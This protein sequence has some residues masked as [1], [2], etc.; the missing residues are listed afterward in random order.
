MIDRPYLLKYISEGDRVLLYGE[1]ED[2][3][4][5]SYQYLKKQSYFRIIGIVTLDPNLAV[6]PAVPIYSPDQLA[7][8]LPADYDKVVLTA[9]HQKSGAE[10]YQAIRESGVDERRIVA[11]YI[12]V[13]KAT[14]ISLEDFLGN[15]IRLK[16]ELN[17]FIDQ[18]YGSLRYFDPLVDQLR[19]RSEER[20]LLRQKAKDFV[21]I[22]SP[23]ENIVFLYILYRGNIFDSELMKYLMES[24]LEI[25]QP[26]LRNFLYGIYNDML[27]MCFQHEEYRFPEYYRLRRAL[28]EKLCE[29][30]GLQIQARKGMNGRIRRICMM[31]GVLLSHKLAPTLMSIRLSGIL[32]ELGYEVKVMVLDTR[33]NVSWEFPI[34]RPL[35]S[36]AYYGSSIFEEYHRE[37]FHPDVSVD[38][39]DISEPGKHM[40]RLLD[41]ILSFSP[42]LIIDMGV[43]NS[44]LSCIYSKYFRTLYV[45]SGGCQSSIWF[46]HYGVVNHDM[47]ME[48]NRIYHSVDDE[49]EVVTP[50][51]PIAPKLKGRY[52]RDQYP[53]ASL[54]RDDFVL[55]SVGNRIGTE[56]T[57]DFI[58]VVCEK[59]LV[60]QNIKWLI[61]G[62]KNKYLSHHY[63]ELFAEGKIVY[64]EY[65]DDL[66]SLYQ[67][68]DVFMSPKRQGGGTSVFWAMYCGLPVAQASSLQ[69]DAL[70]IM[71]PGN[72]AGETYEQM[73]DFILDMW[74]NPERYAEV[75][76]R[77]CERA[78]QID[79]TS[80]Q[81]WKRFLDILE[82]KQ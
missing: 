4:W 46:T 37:V 22:L 33:S 34:F 15:P 42:D 79:V 30:Y 55:I 9:R 26:E 25:N 69:S 6:E 58:D 23:I 31:H 81:E 63:Q 3:I 44:I 32:A 18:K 16:E 73:S 20:R 68:C 14:N 38:Y 39:T 48:A 62:G 67:I 53:L 59:L 17:E 76:K 65:E 27:S 1:G 74:E 52:D 77:N 12:Y 35:H 36:V 10:M 51:V 78:L 40:Q 60:K 11:A 47:F 49:K 72:A 2:D 66:P 56:L 50:L 75:S 24:V 80:K 28:G 19:K 64:I 54:K 71:G 21:H 13:G 41:K 7:A 57:K 29:M 5:T 8:I 82:V 43:E 70:S 45:P 61:V